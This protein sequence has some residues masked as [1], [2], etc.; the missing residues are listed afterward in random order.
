MAP[1]YS[2]FHGY[3]GSNASAL[4]AWDIERARWNSGVDTLSVLGSV[5]DL[6][7]TGNEVDQH[8]ESLALLPALRKDLGR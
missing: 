6:E 3:G 7:T 8:C 1:Q 5:V 4:F 2:V